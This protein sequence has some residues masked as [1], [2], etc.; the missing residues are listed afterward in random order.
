MLVDLQ[1]KLAGGDHDQCADRTLHLGL[2][3]IDHLNEG[4]QEGCGFPCPGLCAGD[5]VPSLQRGWNGLGLNGGWTCDAHGL[6]ALQQAG[7]EAE[8]SVS[9]IL[10]YYGGLYPTRRPADEVIE[11]VGLTEKA[12]AKV[13]TLSGGQRRRLDMAL[14]LIGDPDLLFLDEPTTGFDPSARRN[15]WE[16]ISGLRSLGKT[17][18]LTTHY[19]DEAQNLADRVGVL[20]DGRLVAEGPPDTIAGREAGEAVI[21]FRTSSGLAASE[22]PSELATVAIADGTITI[23]TGETT[24]ALNVLTSWALERGIELGGLTVSR[25]SLEDVYLQLAGSGVEV[26]R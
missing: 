24:R 7:I 8:L 13:K 21:R 2:V 25:P 4:E 17:I 10:D 19:M 20:V 12:G 9:E 23:T 16:L 3:A 15:S 18:L 6:Q 1:G 14:V 26:E 5:Q 22:L 11:S